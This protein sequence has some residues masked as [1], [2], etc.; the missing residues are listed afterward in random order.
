MAWRCVHYEAAFEHYLRANCLAYV[1]VDEARKALTTGPDDPA[2]IVAL[3]SFDFVVHT[4]G[5][6]MLADVKG[7]RGRLS[8]DGSRLSG[9]QTWVTRDDVESLQRWRTLFGTECEAA[10]IFMYWLDGTPGDALLE[11]AFVY[12]GRW[13]LLR[14][15]NLAAYREAMRPRSRRWSTLAMPARAFGTSAQSPAWRAAPASALYRLPEPPPG[16]ESGIPQWRR[17][18]SDRRAR[19]LLQVA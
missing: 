7:R 15:V 2:A 12:R 6:V 3:K 17:S 19:A 11:S 8:A 16:R 18:E 1:A 10:F 14:Q 5:G 4:P 13:Y 9:A